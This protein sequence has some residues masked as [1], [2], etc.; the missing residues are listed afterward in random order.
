M[1]SPDVPV[2]VAGEGFPQAL[3]STGPTLSNTTKKIEILEIYGYPLS[4]VVS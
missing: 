2:K 1:E 3:P 4:R